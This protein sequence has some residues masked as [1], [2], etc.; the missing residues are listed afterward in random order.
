M[1]TSKI[2]LSNRT[3]QKAENLKK[4]FPNLHLINWGEITDFNMIINATTIGL[5]E[6]DEIK[7]NYENLGNNKFFYDI[8][9]NHKETNFLKKAKT[10]GN[11]IENGKMMFIYQAHQ[12]FTIWHKVMP[13]INN[14]IIKFLNND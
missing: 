9:Y 6:S 1:G 13:E 14:E 10:F 12:A 4:L 2:F 8:I 3:R 11:K 7:L 5:K